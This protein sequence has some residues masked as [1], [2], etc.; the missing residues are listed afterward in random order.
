MYLEAKRA[1][2]SSADLPFGGA[3]G[4]AT[5]LRCSAPAASGVLDDR[6]NTKSAVGRVSKG[7]RLSCAVD[8][9]AFTLIELILV[10]VL[11]AVVIAVVAPSLSNFFHGRELDSEARRFVSLARYGQNQAVSVGSPM[12]LWMD[13]TEGTYG[14]REQDG[15][16]AR[17]LPVASS[18]VMERKR[19]EIVDVKQPEFRLADKLRFELADSG[20]TNGRIVTIRFLPDGA[21]DEGSVRSLLIW[22]EGR[23]SS[24]KSKLDADSESIWIAQSRDRSRYEVVNKTNALERVN[25]RSELPNGVY[26]R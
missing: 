24:G 25:S 15:N 2:R 17:D 22:Q 3:V 14:L 11:L 21:I 12:I 8:C 23:A 10:M 4:V 5:R 1:R 20:R 6:G 26:V 9:R 13:Q 16:T 18:L 19:H 7:A